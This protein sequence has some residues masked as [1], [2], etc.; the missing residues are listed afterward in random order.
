MVS[1]ALILA[2]LG[3]LEPWL[4]WDAPPSCPDAAEVTAR[5]ESRLGHAI[6]ADEFEVRGSI[7]EAEGGAWRLTLQTTRADSTDVRTIA[8]D[9]CETL[10]DAAA[11]VV[12]LSADPIAV[13]VGVLDA[14]VL[15][16]PPQ[17]PVPQ[18]AQTPEVPPPTRDPE[19]RRS[20]VIGSMPAEPAGAENGL[21]GP[22]LTLAVGGG[23][24]LGALPG[25][26]GG[27]T[28]SVSALW[29]RVRLEFGGWY[30]APRTASA[31]T[32]RVR[33][34]MGSAFVRGCGRLG[35]KSIEVPL[36][37]GLELGGVRGEG[38]RAPDARVAQ[39]F[40]VAPVVSAGLHGWIRPRLA[41]WGRAE[42]SV[43]IRRTGFE[44][45]DPGDPVELFVPGAVSGR[46][47]LGI[48]GKIRSVGDGSRPAR[49]RREEGRP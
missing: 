16:A 48:E 32:A 20:G 30:E 43:P 31:G 42:A 40:W 36:C 22:E 29:P 19:P 33:V 1:G 5:T 45:R 47:W 41:L 28:L 46:L 38:D 21:Q 8:S 4:H 7:V 35:R 15:N 12:A 34:Q 37:G 3:T 39:G 26:S 44:L 6:E 14:G 13:S 27:P 25:L 17:L 24:E 11:L 23:L 2:A 9:D 49:R 10:A 18:A